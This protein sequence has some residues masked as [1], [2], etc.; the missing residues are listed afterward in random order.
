MLSHPF[1]VFYDP[2]KFKERALNRSSISLSEGMRSK[3]FGGFI[4]KC[5]LFFVTLVMGR[6]VA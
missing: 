3:F 1:L 6:I 4:F 2:K 5:K